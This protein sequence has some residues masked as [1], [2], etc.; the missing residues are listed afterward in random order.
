MVPN[1]DDCGLLIIDMQE[2]LLNTLPENVREQLLRNTEIL[3][4]L[5]KDMGGSI[6][7]TEQYPKGIGPTHPRLKEKLDGAIRVEKVAF[8]CLGESDFCEKVVPH[9]P[10][11]LIIVG[12]EAHICVLMTVIDFIAEDEDESLEIY[13]PQDCIASRNKENWK[14]AVSQMFNFGVFVT[15][16]ETLVYQALQEAGNDMF[17]KYAKRLK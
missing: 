7:Y 14:N 9:I 5:V 10:E 12:V 15:N 8:S 1:Y 17:R 4:D 6:F 13:V 16:T 11:S 2:K 3:I